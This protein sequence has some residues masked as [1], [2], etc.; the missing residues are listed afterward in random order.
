MSS[1]LIRV[2]SLLESL[3]WQTSFQYVHAYH[4]NPTLASTLPAQVLTSLAVQTANTDVS[5]AQLHCGQCNTAFHE[6]VHSLCKLGP[7]DGRLHSQPACLSFNA[8]GHPRPLPPSSPITQLAITGLAP[9]SGWSMT[10][11][12]KRC[13][14]GIRSARKLGEN[15]AGGHQRSENKQRIDAQI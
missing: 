13:R 2:L 10:V 3:R 7:A 1:H 5:L 4:D 14:R 8:C 11:L 6:E 9:I 12:R 15:L